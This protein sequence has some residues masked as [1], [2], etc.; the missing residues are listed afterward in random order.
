MANIANAL[1]SF[2]VRFSVFKLL[3]NCTDMYIF[4]ALTYFKKV[5]KFVL[6]KKNVKLSYTRTREI[7]KESLGS[8][9]LKAVDF[10]T[11]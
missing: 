4:R 8:I 11:P 1:K 2:N 3:N 9:G 6:R 5:N 10:G 7:L